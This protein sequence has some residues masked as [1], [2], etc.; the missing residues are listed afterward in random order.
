MA[1]A[2]GGAWH[3][4]P[5]NAAP[6]AWADAPRNPVGYCNLETLG[7]DPATL[8]WQPMPAVEPPIEPAVETEIPEPPPRCGDRVR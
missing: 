4:K 5:E 1:L 8:N 2:G 7:I 6:D 3:V